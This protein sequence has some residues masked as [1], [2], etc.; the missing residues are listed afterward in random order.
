MCIFKFGMLGSQENNISL[1]VLYMISRKSLYTCSKMNKTI[2]PIQVNPAVTSRADH[3]S[4]VRSDSTSSPTV[5]SR[6]FSDGSVSG[7]DGRD[8]CAVQEVATGVL[9]RR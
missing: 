4:F 5:T 1:V 9:R 2:H 3:A 6:M 7:G 8:E